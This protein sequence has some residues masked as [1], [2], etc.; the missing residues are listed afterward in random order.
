M[1]T[2][3]CWMSSSREHLC[4]KCYEFGFRLH[5]LEL[6]AHPGNVGDE[7]VWAYVHRNRR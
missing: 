7:M 6:S 2:D 4:V 1:D 5:H 3:F